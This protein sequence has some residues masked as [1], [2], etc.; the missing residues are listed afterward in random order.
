MKFMVTKMYQQNASHLFSFF[1][2]VTFKRVIHLHSK[3]LNETCVLIGKYTQ[4]HGAPNPW[5]SV[6][7]KSVSFDE[8]DR[9]SEILFKQME[10]QTIHFRLLTKKVVYL[11]ATGIIENHSKLPLVQTNRKFETFISKVTNYDQ[12]LIFH[13]WLTNDSIWIIVCG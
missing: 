11:S 12:K 5:I 8:M 13:L 2:M 6:R 10:F 7:K 4:W 3:L 9:N 1:H